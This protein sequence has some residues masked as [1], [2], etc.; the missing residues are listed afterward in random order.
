MTTC[1]VHGLPVVY[2]SPSLGMCHACCRDLHRQLE[3]EALREVRRATLI[4]LRALN[5]TP[6]DEHAGHDE[7]RPW[8]F[9]CRREVTA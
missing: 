6:L 7:P 5:L 4:R 8:C 9:L 3:E 2:T 1:A